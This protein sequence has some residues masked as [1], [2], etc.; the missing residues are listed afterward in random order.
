MYRQSE[1]IMKYVKKIFA[2]SNCG[3][4]F[5]V[6]H[7]KNREN[8]RFWTFRNSWASASRLFPLKNSEKNSEKFRIE[9]GRQLAHLHIANSS[10]NGSSKCCQRNIFNGDT[11]WSIASLELMGN[12]RRGGAPF[13]ASYANAI[14]QVARVVQLV[15]R[16]VEN[17]QLFQTINSFEWNQAI[18]LK[19][20]TLQVDHVLQ[21]AVD[22]TY[23]IVVKPQGSQAR[24]I[25]QSFNTLKSYT[26]T[27]TSTIYLW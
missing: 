25:V 15:V 1:N 10:F 6:G 27:A 2:D 19:K 3:G 16:N 13:L 23:Q 4:P 22:P 18:I 24:V 9:H 8:L 12:I 20:Q 14:T 26:E 7:L 5:Y 17:D 21:A 11:Y